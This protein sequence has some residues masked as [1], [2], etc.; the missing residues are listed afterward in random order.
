[1]EASS[2][3]VSSALEHHMVD[4]TLTYYYNTITASSVL[5]A[6]DLTQ[7]LQ[8]L[9][10]TILLEKYP[11]HTHPIIAMSFF[12]GDLCLE[13]QIEIYQLPLHPIVLNF[14]S[15]CR[16]IQDFDEFAPSEPITEVSK[17]TDF[18]NYPYLQD[19]IFESQFWLQTQGWI[20]ARTCYQFLVDRNI[21]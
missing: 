2:N 4:Q 9:Q 10:L 8:P 11:Y 5:Y 14:H 1:M 13:D 12:Q 18:P 15:W 19:Q 20:E 3:I 7:P 21:T 17:P 6:V 16:C